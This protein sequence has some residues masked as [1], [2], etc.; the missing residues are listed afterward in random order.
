[1]SEPSLSSSSIEGDI[2]MDSE[3]EDDAPSGSDEE[4]EEDGG[5]K[6]KSL[7]VGEWGDVGL[8]ASIFRVLGSPTQDTWPVSLP[9]P[10][11]PSRF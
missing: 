5:C 4:E 3:E 10:F 8:V 1:M 7:F 6:R 11:C 9:P 2:E